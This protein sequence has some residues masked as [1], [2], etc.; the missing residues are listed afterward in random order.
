MDDIINRMVSYMMP[1]PTVALLDGHKFLLPAKCRF[2]LSD[3]SHITQLLSG[4]LQTV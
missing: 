1:T 4:K 2:L 3:V